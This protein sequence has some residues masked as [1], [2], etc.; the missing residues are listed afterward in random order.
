MAA[1]KSHV[2]RREADAVVAFAIK[3]RDLLGL[4]SWRIGVLEEPADGDA[5]ASIST[6]P[7]RWIAEVKLSD[8]WMKLS[9]DER[10]D[11][12]V[13]EVCHLLHVGVNHV[14]EDAQ[15]LMHDHEWD[16]LNASYHRATEYMVDHLAG[17][18]DAHYQLQQAWDE[19][20]QR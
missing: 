1:P 3:V 16:A 14:I 8:Q 2:T 6:V 7:G 4:P 15:S 9:S 10:R 11:T 12:I 19:V 5:L 17:F 20:H 13:H 18:L